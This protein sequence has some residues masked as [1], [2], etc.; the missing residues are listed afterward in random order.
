[1]ASPQDAG[2]THIDTSRNPPRPPPPET[3]DI[4]HQEAQHIVVSAHLLS[5]GI[6]ELL[7]LFQRTVS[8]VPAAP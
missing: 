1:V 3:N 5:S 2:H 4:T 8:M 7:R 6:Q